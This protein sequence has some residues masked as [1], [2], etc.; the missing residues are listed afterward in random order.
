[1]IN[2]IIKPRI[3]KIP[4]PIAATFAI[5]SNSFLLGFFKMCQTRLDF[6]KNDFIEVNAFIN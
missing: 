1:M 2:A 5:V 4:I 3:P 6:R